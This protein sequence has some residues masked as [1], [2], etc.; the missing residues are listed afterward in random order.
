M[1]GLAGPPAN[2]PPDIG[3]EQGI[4]GQLAGAALDGVCDE[5]GLVSGGARVPIILKQ[6]ALT[7]RFS[8]Q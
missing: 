2:H 5:D 6:H 7:K 1:P 4:A 3:L 8:P